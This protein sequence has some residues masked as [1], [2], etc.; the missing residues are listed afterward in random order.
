MLLAAEIVWIISLAIIVLVVTP[1]VLYLCWRLVRGARN[2][3]HHFALTLQAA[4]GVIKST[5]AVP[6]LE[7]TI[8]VAAGMLDTAGSIDKSSGAIEGLLV[9]RLE[10]GVG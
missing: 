8:K 7:D 6:A 5:A 2:I 4:V 10:K 1:L 9:G 3:E